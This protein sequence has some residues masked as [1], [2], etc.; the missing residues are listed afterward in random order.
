M[1]TSRIT[2][3]ATVAA[4]WFGGSEAAHAD[5]TAVWLLK[6]INSARAN[7][8]GN[9]VVTMVSE[10]SAYY[11]PASLGL[12]H[13]DK[14][15]SFVAP[16]STKWIPELADDFRLKSWSVSAGASKKLL[17]RSSPGETNL[18]F[19]LAYS[20][21]RLSYGEFALTGETGIVLE[22]YYPYD[23]AHCLA[24][25]FGYERKV[26]IGI[27][28]AIKFVD[29]R[30]AVMG[31][32]AD[33][34][35]GHGDGTAH[36]LGLM[37]SVPIH[38]LSSTGE[39]LG[40]SSNGQTAVEVTPTIAYVLDNL[41]S[42]MQYF[43]VSQSDDFPKL[44]RMG[45][46]VL[47]AFTRDGCEFGSLRGSVESE[48]LHVD[49]A[50]SQLKLGL[51]VGALKALFLRFGGFEPEGSHETLATFGAGL[52]LRPL[53]DSRAR[54][55]DTSDDRGFG[56]YLRRHLDVGVDYARYAS[57]EDNSYSKTWFYALSLTF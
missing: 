41:G 21:T 50:T 12:W 10:E 24:V 23:A 3:W 45:L 53:F 32:G 38:K 35:D 17:R 55:N 8:M 51:E 43:D 26:R 36:Q 29:S 27:G 5:N 14:T 2:A 33:Q 56:D 19:G 57:N 34:D 9:C 37:V 20:V 13:L 46:S 7:G 1:R 54:G 42:G 6:D 16:H 28:Y 52:R 49:E 48:K 18:S 4:V 31:A 47:V 15:F 40:E 22:R 25:G 44:S 11:N 30:L 39:A